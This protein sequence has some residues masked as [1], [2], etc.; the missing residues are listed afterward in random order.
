[1]EEQEKPHLLPV[2]L[3][4]VVAHRHKEP[5]EQ[6]GDDADHP[7]YIFPEPRVGYRKPKGKDQEG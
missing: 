4:G 5:A 1:M 6:A 2:D 7:T 3:F